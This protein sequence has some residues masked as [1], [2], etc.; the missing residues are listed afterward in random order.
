MKTTKAVVIDWYN[1]A[2][3]RMNFLVPALKILKVNVMR[4]GCSSNWRE[5]ISF[6]THYHIGVEM[7]LVVIHL[8]WLPIPCHQLVQKTRSC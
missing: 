7:A 2:Y 3:C 6:S 5:Q 1:L 8:Y 4:A